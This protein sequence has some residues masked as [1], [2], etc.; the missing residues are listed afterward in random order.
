MYKITLF[1]V[2]MHFSITFEENLWLDS[3]RTFGKILS[4]ISLMSPSEK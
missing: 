1:V 2:K 4:K 3:W